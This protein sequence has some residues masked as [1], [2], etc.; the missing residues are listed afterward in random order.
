M[1]PQRSL[2]CLSNLENLN[3]LFIKE[4]LS[5]GERLIRL[6]TIAIHQMTLLSDDPAMKRLEERGRNLHNQVQKKQP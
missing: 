1:P 2:C 3:A 5:Q 6:N 4:G